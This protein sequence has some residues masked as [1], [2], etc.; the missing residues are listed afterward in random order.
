MKMMEFVRGKAFWTIDFFKGKKIKSALTI[1]NNCESGIWNE[2]QVK[3]YQKHQLHKLL[4]HAKKTVPFYYNQN[5]T[6]LKNWPVPI[7]T[8]FDLVMKMYYQINT[9]KKA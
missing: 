6:V 7:K 2:D 5:D 4:I 8:S 9:K 1:L 3:V